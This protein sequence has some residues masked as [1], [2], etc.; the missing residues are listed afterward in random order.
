M[1]FF[2]KLTQVLHV[3]TGGALVILLF[4][5]CQIK[6][7]DEIVKDPIP[8][9]ILLGFLKLFINELKHSKDQIPGCF[10]KEWVRKLENAHQTSLYFPISESLLKLISIESVIPS[11]HL[12]F[13]RFLLLLPS[14]LLSI[15]VF[16]K[17]S[18]LRIRWPKSW[19]FSFN[20][21]K[22]HLS[23]SVRCY[24]TFWPTQYF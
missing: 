3:I 5:E 21:K 16:S 7:V 12:T 13:S 4:T 9:I 15:G 11:N 8:L 18:A 22:V 1:F 14:V 10:K 17:E 2:I 20:N 23:F 19:N 6:N 24:W